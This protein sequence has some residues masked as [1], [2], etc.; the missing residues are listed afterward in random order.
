MNIDNSNCLRVAA[1]IRVSTSSSSQLNSFDNQYKFFNDYV[2]E[3]IEWNLV[4]IYKDEGVTGTSI[5]KRKGFQ[6]M[7]ADALEKKIDLILTKEVSRFARNIVDSLQYVRKLKDK[8]VYIIFLLDN[9]DTRDPDFELRLTLMSTF[10]QEESRKLS[11]RVKWGYKRQM[12]KGVVFGGHL[13]GYRI[14]NGKFTIV[15]EEAKIV[16]LIFNKYLVEKKGL[17]TIVKELENDGIPSYIN[18]TNSKQ[19]CNDKWSP[20]RIHRILNN[21]KY[22]GDLAQQKTWT[23]DFLSHKSQTNR[24]DVDLV[25]ITDHHPNEA[26]ITRDLWNAT[27]NELK[28]R[29]GSGYKKRSLKKYWCSG[30][31]IC[32]ECKKDFYPT[33]KIHSGTSFLYWRCTGYTLPNTKTHPHCSNFMV[34]DSSLKVI[35]TSVMEFLVKYNSKLKEEILNEIE[36]LSIGFASNLKEDIS[37]RISDLKQKKVQ[38]LELRV[39]DEITKDDF[40]KMKSQIDTELS[41]LAK[42]RNVS[43][44]ITIQ[45]RQDLNTITNVSK[46]LENLL[47]VEDI[48]EYI[49]SEIIDYIYIYKGKI[50]DLKLKLI[51]YIF[52]VFYKTYGIKDNYTTQI[53]KIEYKHLSET[54]DEVPL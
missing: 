8:G 47:Y 44:D 43:E 16:R 42:K 50:V 11:E 35:V 22:V 53:L 26:I 1:Y 29:S 6:E 33:T 41:L 46:E 14:I 54:I 52:K 20:I 13:L 37:T 32:G 24:G 23:S 30:K 4:K 21:E 51:P 10:A 48:Y 3:H 40:I 28:I 39:S 45:A 5:S 25:Y 12:K 17:Y 38:L 49:F 9:I 31:V 2:K 19:K 27:Q 36:A 18:P 15:E 7:I 34:R